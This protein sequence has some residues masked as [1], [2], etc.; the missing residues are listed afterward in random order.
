ME[1]LSPGL[2]PAMLL[3]VLPLVFGTLAVILQDDLSDAHVD[4]PCMRMPVKRP[5]LLG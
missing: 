5:G 3:A 4:M 2:F 1:L